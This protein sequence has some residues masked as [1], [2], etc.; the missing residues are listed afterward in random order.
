LEN[1]YFFDNQPNKDFENSLNFPNQAFCTEALLDKRNL[2][3]IIGKNNEL[4][5]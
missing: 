2:K 5:E 1:L 3:K 4:N